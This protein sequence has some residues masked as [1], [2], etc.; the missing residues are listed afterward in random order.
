MSK[1]LSG[2]CMCGTVK[3]RVK[4][5]FK[6]F[7]QCHCI[8]CQHLTGTAFASNIFTNIDNIE[9]LSGKDNIAH[10][11]HPTR[12][13]SKNFCKTCGSPLPYINKSKTS[14]VIPAGSLVDKPS[15]KPEANIFMEEQACWLEGGRNAKKFPGFPE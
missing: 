10:F 6:A 13:F 1:R 8:Q 11:E 4:E 15:I 3:Y 7:Y 5:D 2:Q 14:L 9:W 12:Q